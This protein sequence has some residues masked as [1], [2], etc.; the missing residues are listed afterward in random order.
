VEILEWYAAVEGG[1]AYK[2]PGKDSPFM[3]KNIRC[4][5]CGECCLTVGDAGPFDFD[6]EGK[7]LKLVKEDGKWLCTA[8]ADLPLS[9]VLPP[10]KRNAP[11]CVITFKNGW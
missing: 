1:F 4:S 11:N 5:N 7:C 8:G 2:E 9:C 10:P 3:V 6:D